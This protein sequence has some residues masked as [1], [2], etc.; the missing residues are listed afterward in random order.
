LKTESLRHTRFILLGVLFLSGA[1]GL[2]LI[3]FTRGDYRNALRHFNIAV[4]HY[5]KQAQ[6]RFNRALA[7]LKL[8]RPADARHEA[9]VI[10]KLETGSAHLFSAQLQKNYEVRK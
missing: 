4:Q 3:Y 10:K 1:N 7:L 2:G 8:K 9:A 5:P 6:I